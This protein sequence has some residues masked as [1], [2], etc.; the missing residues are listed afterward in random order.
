MFEP[1]FTTKEPGRGTGLGLAVSYSIV[2]K[3]GGSM[4]FDSTLGRGSVFSVTIP[5]LTRAPEADHD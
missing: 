2:E 4:E 3:H 5:V 1:F